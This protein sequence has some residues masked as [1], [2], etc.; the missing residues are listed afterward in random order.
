MEK[1]NMGSI[2]AGIIECGKNKEPTICEHYGMKIDKFEELIKDIL[3]SFI[4]CNSFN[5]VLDKWFSNLNEEDRIKVQAYASAS[6][7]HK[8]LMG[9]K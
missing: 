1:K 6:H 9:N 2:I 7:R 8:I 4:K 3:C 5:E